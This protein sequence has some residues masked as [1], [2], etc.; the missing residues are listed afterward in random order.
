MT[1]CH[2]T[3]C[4]GLIVFLESSSVLQHLAKRPRVV[5]EVSKDFPSWS[6]GEAIGIVCGRAEETGP[7]KGKRL[8]MT[9]TCD[10]LV[11]HISE[12]CRGQLH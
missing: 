4:D 1:L 5:P 2:Y 6:L 12:G 11:N 10:G 7:S 9:V 8:S 3:K